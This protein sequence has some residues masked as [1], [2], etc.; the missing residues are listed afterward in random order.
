MPEVASGLH[1]TIRLPSL[2]RE[3]ALIGAAHAAGIEIA[4]LSTLWLPDSAAGAPGRYGLILGFAGIP[5]AQ[6][7]EAVMTLKAAWA[8]LG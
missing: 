3:Q 8:G 2:A 6:I 1:V 5:E 7:T 4:A